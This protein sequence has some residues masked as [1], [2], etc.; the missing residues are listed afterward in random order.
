M[1][2]H[3]YVID[4]QSAPSLRADLNSALQAI[5]TQNSSATAPTTTYANMIWYDTANNQLKKRN[6]ADSGW[7][8][9]GTIDE[10]L[11]TFTPSG[12]RALA[13]Q[14]QAEVG[15][16]N[17]TLMTP[18]RTEEHMLANALGWTQTWQNV[19]G[20]RAVSTSYQNT[21]G[22]PIQVNIDANS[23][24]STG[25]DIQVSTDNVNWVKVSQTNGS[26]GGFVSSAVIVPNGH[27]YRVNG[28]AT[29][30]VWAELR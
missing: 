30:K 25:R 21:T 19:I 28:A 11:G 15:T 4:N 7:I 12:E 2:T 16:D 22:R 1:A 20:S 18:L 26:A 23:T 10:G 5:V 27:Y 3:D 24:V 17:T 9:L 29:L 8:T 6:E 13:T 14:V